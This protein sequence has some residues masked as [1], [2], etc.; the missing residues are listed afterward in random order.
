[1][2]SCTGPLTSISAHVEPTG[3]C[4]EH[5]WFG[6]ILSPTCSDR[7]PNTRA[8]ECRPHLGPTPGAK[9]QG[10]DNVRVLQVSKC[11]HIQASGM[12]VT[13]VVPLR[14]ELD[15][16]RDILP[17]S[18]IHLHTSKPGNHNRE[19]IKFEGVIGIPVGFIDA[20]FPTHGHISMSLGRAGTGSL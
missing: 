4:F 12:L 2:R 11:L 13:A 6:Y 9:A 14:Q 15:C 3:L 10:T 20:A 8:C 17:E 1:M 5:V 19:S 18:R 16:N 7:H